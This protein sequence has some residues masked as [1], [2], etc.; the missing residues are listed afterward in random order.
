MPSTD[1]RT[2]ALPRQAYFDPSFF[3]KEQ[4]SVFYDNWVCVGFASD[5]TGPG[6]VKP[7]NLA[8]RSLFMMKDQQA[9]VGV[10]HN[11]CR[12]RGYPLVEKPACLKRSLVCPY[13]AWNYA[14]DGSFLSA[15]HYAGLGRHVGPENRPVD[16]L[17]RVRAE[18]WLDMVFVNLSGDAPTLT[19]YLAPLLKR[20]SDFDLSLLRLGERCHYDVECNWKLAVENFIDI[21][22][23][24][25][26]HRDLNSYCAM[27]VC[28]FVAGDDLFLGQGTYPY[29]P[30]DEAV[31]KLPSFPALSERMQ[32]S[33]EALW[34]SPNLLVTLFADNL[35]IIRVEPVDA[36]RCREDI[37]V[38]FVGEEALGPENA[39]FRQVT[40]D[41]FR[42]FNSEDIGIVEALQRGLTSSDYDGGHYSPAFDRNVGHF[43]S[44]IRRQIEKEPKA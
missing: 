37:G 28:Y 2:G 8:G 27:Q 36:S 4:T 15:P 21:Y 9:R 16:G 12:H 11:F 22:H 29:E 44:I 3:Q 39:R 17:L 40:V 23:L 5:L 6:A 35:R 18:Q 20:W 26:V 13:H 43:Q 42:D 10:F 41:R 24:P 7:F 30:D 34:L 32:K 14:L 38:F 31:G 25:P 19:Q 33:T 1:Y